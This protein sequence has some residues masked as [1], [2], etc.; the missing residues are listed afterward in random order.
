MKVKLLAG[1]ALAAVFAASGACAHDNGWY[2]AVDAGAHYMENL[3]FVFADANTGA[4]ER[5]VARDQ[6]YDW[7]AFARLG[8]RISPNVRIEVEGGY[9]PGSLDSVVDR[10]DGIA[11][12]ATGTA[13]TPCGRPSGSIV[14]MFSKPI[15]HSSAPQV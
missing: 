13:A 6:E 3:N 14:Q 4:N 9:R 8:Y 2:G 1:A 12:C 5:F 7:T 10:V 15:R 11:L